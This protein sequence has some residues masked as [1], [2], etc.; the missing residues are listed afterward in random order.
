MQICVNI[1]LISIF[2][3]FLVFYHDFVIGYTLILPMSQLHTQQL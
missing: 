2:S 3:L 1:Y